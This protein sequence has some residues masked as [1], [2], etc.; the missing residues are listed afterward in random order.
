MK[1]GAP[2]LHAG[3]IKPALGADKAF[4]RGED[5]AWIAAGADDKPGG[6]QR[7]LDLKFTDQRQTDLECP[8]RRGRRGDAA[9]NHPPR[10]RQRE[11]RHLCGR[12]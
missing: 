12:R 8:F 2:L 1:I 11:F 5:R 4:E 9:R 6:D 3:K 10:N 7:V